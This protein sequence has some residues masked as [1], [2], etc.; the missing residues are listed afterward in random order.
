MTPLAGVLPVF[1]TPFAKDESIDVATLETE[2][3]WLFDQGANG[4]VMAMPFE[5]APG[6]HGYRHLGHDG[7][8]LIRS[9]A[10]IFHG[11]ASGARAP[12]SVSEDAVGV[13]GAHLRGR[14][15]LRTVGTSP[16]MHR[17]RARV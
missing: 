12:G 3:D 6:E 7:L 16:A 17:V 15:R 1:Q 5:R 2:V 9:H 4:L 14:D 8:D 13:C 11:V 10:F